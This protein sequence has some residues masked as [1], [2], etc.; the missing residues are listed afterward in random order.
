MS[1]TAKKADVYEIVTGRIIEQ[2]EK[3][4]VP[5]RKP[6]TVD[7]GPPRN[8]ITGR[9]YNSINL[10][11]LNTFNYPQNLFLTFKQVTEIGAKIKGGAKGHLIAFWKWPKK[12]EEGKQAEK[13]NTPYLRYYYVFNID[14][15]VGIPES[16]L[17][18]NNLSRPNDPIESCL[19]IVN[20][21]PNKPKIEHLS[22]DACYRVRTDSV[23]MPNIEHF[24]DDDSYYQTL[25]HELIHST[26]HESRLNRKEIVNPEKFA[27]ENYAIEELTA[28]IGMCYLMSEAG[29]GEMHFDNSVAYIQTWLRRLRNDKRLIVYASSQAQKATDFI[30]N[31]KE[32]HE[33]SAG[34]LDF[35][36]P[37]VSEAV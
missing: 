4:I 34:T 27:S 1:E 33:D 16:I 22:K 30:L 20:E 31:V 10:L 6:W 37:V 3:G 15:C 21:M 28:Q 13:Q 12:N 9:K 11:L 7:A 18:A 17:P 2:L 35:S 29:V 5:W 24:L 23:H 19:K 36:S 26:G 8:L 14:Q 32:K 25:F